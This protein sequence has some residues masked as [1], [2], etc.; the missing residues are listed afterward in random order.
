MAYD[1]NQAYAALSS[2]TDE[3]S[4][5][6]LLSEI[7]IQAPGTTTVAYSGLTAQSVPAF[8]LA[9]SLANA[10][11]NI[12]YIGNTDV[13]K[14][15]DLSQNR[16][17][18][19]KLFEIFDDDPRD[20][21][22][23]AGQFLGG[24]FDPY[25]NRIP[26]GIWDDISSRFMA[27]AS[28]DVRVIVFDA[29]A[30]RI[31]GSSELST[32]LNN[33]SVT[34]IEGID[35]ADLR[36]SMAKAGTEPLE[37]VFDR[38]KAASIT[39]LGLAGVTA[40]ALPD[41]S[42]DVRMRDF[43]S[44][45]ILD[46]EGYIKSNPDSIRELTAYLF[47]I[48]E[49]GQSKLQELL[50]S[51]KT[52]GEV[53][54]RGPGGKVMSRAGLIGLVLSGVI[55]GAQASTQAAKGDTR[56]AMRTI[57]DWAADQAGAAAGEVL[58][59]AVGGI[60]LGILAAGGLVATAPA[61][62][63]FVTM[64]AM[65]GGF[66]GG[67]AGKDFFALCQ[68]LDGNGRI[69]LMDKLATVLFGPN[70]AP[71]APLPADLNGGGRY[72]IDASLPRE[73]IVLQAAADIAW[74][75]ALRELNPFVITDVSYAAQNAD[76]SLDLYD[77]QT[78]EGQMTQ[79][80]LEDRGAM[81]AWK[82]RFDRA[83]LKGNR[84]LAAD[85]V[86]GD[87]DFVD[88]AKLGADGKPLQLSIDGRGFSVN[89]HR[90]VFGTRN[91]DAVDGSDKADRLYGMD[92]NDRLSGGA[93]DDYLEGGRGND[94]LIGG[95]G[96][97]VLAGGA[98]DDLLIG[99]AGQ[100]R[101]QGGRG[102]DNYILLAD[103]LAEPH[104][105]RIADVDGLGQL[106]IGRGKNATGLP[107][108]LQTLP[109]S[110]WVAQERQKPGDPSRWTN[111]SFT[112][113]ALATD[114]WL[115]ED[116]GPGLLPTRVLVTRNAADGSLELQFGRAGTQI[117]VEN[118]QSGRLGIEL[119]TGAHDL[120]SNAELRASDLKDWAYLQLAAGVDVYNQLGQDTQALA[121]RLSAPAGNAGT[122]ERLSLTQAQDLL[123]RYQIVT[124][125]GNDGAGFSATLFRRRDPV[126][127]R[128]VPIAGQNPDPYLLVFRGNDQEP[129]RVAG[130]AK[131]GGLAALREINR[132]GFAWAQLDA[133]ERFWSGLSR[134][135]VLTRAGEWVSVAGAEGATQGGLTVLGTG[136]GAHLAAAFTLLHEDR[137]ARGIGIDGP[138]IGGMQD[139]SADGRAITAAELRGKLQDFIRL[140]AYR[141]LPLGSNFAPAFVEAGVFD[142]YAAALEADR[143]SES[144]F[145]ALLNYLGSSYDT[146][147]LPVPADSGLT[148]GWENAWDGANIYASALYRFAADWLGR[149][150]V[151]AGQG[152]TADAST[153]G[154]GDAELRAA[155]NDL[156]LESKLDRVT[157][158][159]DVTT[160]RLTGPALAGTAGQKYLDLL[161]QTDR[162][163]PSALLGGQGYGGRTQSLWVEDAA[164]VD[165]PDNLD[166]LQRLSLEQGWGTNT[167]QRAIGTAG[168]LTRLA[169]SAALAELFQRIDSTVSL[170]A[171][172]AMARAASR[173]RVTASSPV[174]PGGGMPWAARVE[175]LD[176]DSLEQ[177]IAGLG[178]ILG[179]STP[180]PAATDIAGTLDPAKRAAWADAVS[181][182]HQRLGQL[183]VAG[184][185]LHL[186]DLTEMSGEQLAAMGAEDSMSGLATRLALQQGLP[187]ALVD[188][189]GRAYAGIDDPVAR[190]VPGSGQ[191]AASMEWLQDRAAWLAG[192]LT[193]RTHNL[194]DDQLHAVLDDKDTTSGWEARR[195]TYADAQ[196]GTRFSFLP[197]DLSEAERDARPE[198]LVTF[199]RDS[200][201]PGDQL[202][203]TVGA[204]WL[205]GQ[206]GDD[207]LLG[208]AGRD[209][210][211]GGAGD[212]LLQ[213]G[214]GADALRG[215]TGR[216]LL[217]GG[218]GGDVFV[219][220]RGDGV[221]TIIDSDGP[222]N[223]NTLS[224]GAGIGR[225]DLRI[226]R[227]GHT[228]TIHVQAAGADT[229]D[230]IRLMHFSRFTDDAGTPVTSVLAFDDGTQIELARLMNHAPQASTGTLATVT[231]TQ[232]SW[233]SA[234]LPDGLFTDADSDD[235][236]QWR[237]ER[238]NGTAAPAWLQFNPGTRTLFGRPPLDDTIELRVIATDRVGE[239]AH[240]DFTLNVAAAPDTDPVDG[241][242]PAPTLSREAVA[243][244]VQAGSSFTW[245]LASLGLSPLQAASSTVVTLSRADGSSL[246]SWIAYE[247]QTGLLRLTPEATEA[248]DMPLRVVAVNGDGAQSV[249]ALTLNVQ[250]RKAPSA[251]AAL[252][253]LQWEEGPSVA[254]QVPADAFLNLAAGVRYTLTPEDGSALPAG[255]QFDA[256]T[257]RL[258]GAPDASVDS[259]WRLRLTAR[260]V[261]GSTASQ[262]LLVQMAARNDAPQ[263]GALPAT[264]NAVQDQALQWTLPADAFSDEETPAAALAIR[265]T[266]AGGAPLPAWL[267]FDAGT[268]TLS[269]MPQ[270]GDVGTQTIEW[271]ATDPQGAATVATQQLTVSNV[272]D[273]PVLAVPLA[274]VAATQGQALAVDLPRAAFV[275]ADG[276]TLTVELTRADGSA[277]P[278][279]LRLEPAGAGGSL[280]RLSGTPGAGDIGPV[281]VRLTVRDA[282][283]AQASDRF[284]VQV[285]D[286]NDAPQVVQPLAPVTVSAYAPLDVTL[287]ALAFS[288]PD[289]GERLSWQ[290]TQA[291]GS[292][293]PGWLQFDAGTRRLTGRAV[294]ADVGDHALRVRVTD[295]WGATAD[296]L[297]NLQVQAGTVSNQAPTPGAALAPWRA[298]A[299]QTFSTVLPLGLFSDADVF[300]S[301]TFS[302]TQDDGS[303]LP[304]WLQFDPATQ[305][306]IGTVPVDQA[307]GI[308][309]RLTATDRDGA[310][311]HQT[312]SLVIES[313]D[314]QKTGGSGDDT[315]LGSEGND[316]LNGGAGHDSLTG[317]AG[318]DRLDGQDGNDSLNGES[319]DDLLFG[320]NGA[321]RL[322]GGTGADRLEGGSADDMLWG[323]DG[324]DVLDGGAGRDLLIGGSGSDTVAFR[325]GDGIDELRNGSDAADP[326]AEAQATQDIVRLEGIR[327]DETLVRRRFDDLLL[328]FGGGDQLTLT[329]FFLGGAARNAVAVDALRFDDGTVWNVDDLV[330]RSMAGTPGD[331]LLWGLSDTADQLAGAAG[332]DNL[333]GL[334]GDDQLLGE[335]GSDTLDGGD[336]ADRLDGGAG[337]DLL[338]GGAGNDRLVGGAGDDGLAFRSAD[339]N[340][341]G[342]LYGGE[343]DDELA[344]GT[345]DD[346]LA[347]GAGSDTYRFE[348]GDGHDRILSH[349]LWNG[350]SDKQS[351]GEIDRLVFGEGIRPTD[352]SMARE[353]STLVLRLTGSQ[354]RVDLLAYFAGETTSNG[355][356]LDEIRFADGTVWTGEDV[357]AALLRTSSN[358]DQVIGYGDSDDAL[359]GGDGDDTLWGRAGA[360]VLRGGNGRDELQ[361]ETGS[362][363]LEGGAGNDQLDGGADDDQLSGDDGSDLLWGR[364]G[365]DRLLG[366]AGDDTGELY[367]P[368]QIGDTEWKLP[369][370]GLYGGAGDDW[371]EGGTGADTLVGGE[372]SDTYAFWR[373]DGQ[374]R[375]VNYDTTTGLPHAQEA[376]DVDTLR[377][378]PGITPDD[379]QLA[380]D[381]D[382]LVITRSGSDDRIRIERSFV[383][384]S[385]DHGY[386]L[387]AWVFD[388]GRRWTSQDILQ[389]LYGASAQ[390]PQVVGTPAALQATQDETQVFDLPA[391]WFSDAP[392][393]RL[394]YRLGL[395]G[396]LPLPDWLR[397]EPDASGAG[398]GRLVATPG[399]AQVG[400]VRLSLAA[401]DPLG[402]RTE[403]PLILNVQNRND[404]PVAG[405][406]P[407]VL[408]A[409]EDRPFDVT[410][411]A[412]L[413][414]DPDGASDPLS[415]SVRSSDGSTLPDWLSFDP[416][417]R[418]LSGTP[419]NAAVGTTGLRLRATDGGGLWADMPLSVE[420]ANVNDAPHAGPGATSFAVTAY[421]VFTIGL[422]PDLVVDDDAGDTLSLDLRLADGSA[423]PGWLSFD[424]DTATLHGRAVGSD[425]GLHALRL[426]ATDGAG[427]QVD[428]GLQLQIGAGTARNAA[429]VVDAWAPITSLAGA[430]LAW[431]LPPGSFRDADPWDPLT[432]DIRGPGDTALP[433]GLAFDPISG[434]LTGSLG[435]PGDWSFT[436]RA[437]D[438]DGA[439]ALQ[440]LDV[441]VL[442]PALRADGGEASERMDGA[443][444]DDHLRGMGGSDALYGSTGHDTLEGGDGDDALFGGADDDTLFGAAGDDGLEGE[445]GDDRLFGQDGSDRLTG[446]AGDDTLD[447]GTGD[448][449]LTGGSG[450]DNYLWGA[451]D[452]HDRIDNRPVDSG[453][454]GVDQ[455]LFKPGIRPQDLI[456]ERL[457]DVDVGIRLRDGSGS[458]LLERFFEGNRAD[459]ATAIERLRFADGTTWTPDDVLQRASTAVAIDA[460]LRGVDDR[461]NRLAGSTGQDDLRGGARAD[462]LLG[463]A[464]RDRLFGGAGDDRLLGGDGDDGGTVNVGG[465]P[466]QLGL[467]GE[468]GDDEL[469]GGAGN[470]ELSGGRGSDRFHFG[471]GYG[472][473]RIASGLASWLTPDDRDID[474]L[475][476][477]PGIGLSDLRMERQG[478]DL[479]IDI[480]GT[481][482][483]VT[484]AGQFSGDRLAD[485]GGIDA[486]EWADGSRTALRELAD[487]FDRGD[488]RSQTLR[489]F[490]DHDDHL[491]GLAGYDR[492]MGLG[493][494]DWLEGGDDQDTLWGDD[495]NDRLWGGAG[496]D[497]GWPDGSLG[498]LYG[499]AGDDELRGGSGTDYLRGGAGSD[500]YRFERGDGIDRI[501]NWDQH[502]YVVE[503]LPGDRD[504]LIFGEGI[505]P[506]D[507]RVRK[508]GDHLILTRSGTGDQVQVLDQLRVDRVAI[509]S[510]L[511]EIRFA[512]GTVWRE[513]D[514]IARVQQLDGADDVYIG[515]EDLADSVSGGA[516]SDRLY[517]QAGNDVLDGGTGIDRLE[518]GAGDDRL[519]GGE[520]DDGGNF[521]SDMLGGIVAVGGLF[522]GDGD[523]WLDGGAGRDALSG[524]AG[525]DSFNFGLGSGSDVVL[526]FQ[527]GADAA[528]ADHVQLGSGIEAA[529]LTLTR[530]VSDLVLRTPLGDTLSLLGYFTREIASDAVVIRF[531]DGSSWNAG[532]LQQRV[533]TPTEGADVLIL[534][535]EQN[536]AIQAGGGD[537]RVE[538][539]GGDDRVLGGSGNDLLITG[540]GRD[541][542]DGDDGDDVLMLGDG[543]DTGR[544]GAGADRLMGDAGND[545]LW[546]GD[547]DDA[548]VTNAGLT[549]LRGLFGGA[550]DDLLDGGAGRDLL[551]GDAGNDLLLGGAGDDAGD[552]WYQMADATDGTGGSAGAGLYGGAGDD[553]LVGGAG[554]DAM[555]GG[556]GSDNYR[557]GRGEGQDRILDWH[558]VDPL[559]R[560]A[561][562]QAETDSLIFE[563][564][565][566]PEDVRAERTGVDLLLH[567]DGGASSVRVE[568]YFQGDRTDHDYRLDAIQFADGTVWHAADVIRLVGVGT[569]TRDY[570]TAVA[571]STVLAGMDGDDILMAGLY[572][573][574]T[575][576]LTL[577]GGNGHDQLLG[578]MGDETLL[579]GAGNDRLEANAG[580]D[581]LIG[582]PGSDRIDT[583]PG[584][585]HVVFGRGDGSDFVLA[586]GTRTADVVSVHL[587]DGLTPED[588][589]VRV[590][591]N[592][593]QL[594]IRQT[595]DQI[596][597]NM[598][599]QGR[600]TDEIDQILFADGTRWGA[601]D[602]Y[603][604]LG[605]GTA[606]PETMLGLATD[607]H[608]QG[609][610]GQDQ[611]FGSAGQDRLDGDAGNDRL[612]G[613]AG[614]DTLDGGSGDDLL[615]GG[616]G[617]DSYRFGLGGGQ[618]TV[619]EDEG[620]TSPDVIDRLE[621]VGLRPD[622][623]SVSRESER[624]AVITLHASGERV[625][626]WNA[627]NPS[628]SY[629]RIE[630]V[631]FADGTVWTPADLLSATQQG[632][633]GDDVL[634]GTTGNDTLH[635]YAGADT[636]LGLSG[637]DRLW[638][639]EGNDVLD[640]GAGSDALDGGSGNDRA[641]FGAPRSTWTV[642]RV[643]DNHYRLSNGSDVDELL[644]I[645]TLG[646]SDQSLALTTGGVQLDGSVPKTGRPVQWIDGLANNPVSIDGVQWQALTA[647][648]WTDISGATQSDYTPGDAQIGQAL[649]VQ[650][651]FSDPV[652]T[653]QLA[654][655][656][657]SAP[658]E[659]GNHRPVGLPVIAGTA[660]EDATLWADMSGVSDADGLGGF[661]WQWLRD[662][663]AVAGATG[664]SFVPVD[665]DVGGR[666]GLQVAWT[667]GGGTREN[668]V[669]PDTAPVAN[670]NDLPMGQP[671]ILG[672]AAEREKLTA[673]LSGISDADGLG[674]VQLQWT[675]DG[676]A[677]AGATGTS[678]QLGRDDVGHLI[679]LEL[680]YVDGHGSAEVLQAVPTAP[681]IQVN[682]PP[683][684]SLNLAGT[685]AA[686]QTLTA[687]STLADA[688]GL[689]T[690]RWHW[691][692]E[693]A[694][695]W[696]D[697]HD[698]LTSAS[699]TLTA[700]Q[701]GLRVRA[702]ADYLDGGGTWESAASAPSAIVPML[703]FVT[704]T[705][706]AGKDSLSGRKDPDRLVGLA[707]NDTLNGNAGMDLM[708]GGK[709]NDSYVVDHV[710]D[711]IVEAAAE[712][713]D[714]VQSSVS[715]TLP[716]NVDN[717]TL[718]GSAAIN[719][720]GN[721]LDN[722][723]TGN[724]AA[725]VLAGG[726]GNDTLN[727]GAGADTL[728]GGA[729]NDTLIGG[730]GADLYRFGSGGGKDRIQ[731]NDK[732]SG[733][734]DRV[735]FDAGI[736]PADTRFTRNGN[737]LQ[738]GLPGGSDVL[739]IEDWYL[740][741]RYHVEQ[742]A[743]SD[744]TVLTARQAAGL[745]QAIASFDAMATMVADRTGP[746]LPLTTEPL[747]A[748]PMP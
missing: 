466:Q 501:A 226:E 293:L 62:A 24:S 349:D 165:L 210:L 200:A 266:G 728:D 364:D 487:A 286:V 301:L 469:D 587:G 602:L 649:R 32:L 331:D 476:L 30:K 605:L 585:D 417:T 436:L 745:V 123:S 28:G 94:Q 177:L 588:L 329:G 674:D 312:A 710:G 368:Y 560:V 545:G 393:D 706:T 347:G 209:H 400:E 93:G 224:F 457:G 454:D 442:A 334:A 499:G 391:G 616:T 240:I 680:R 214:E 601:A 314:S 744:G 569:A 86:A 620:E 480:I 96:D 35:V 130:V 50:D 660:T 141:D 627:F 320:G 632:S 447:G 233:F 638:G 258:S 603:A 470:D 278:A 509:G 459:S 184:S 373:G 176:T 247:P 29:D 375:I 705:G 485:G 317:R 598:L 345:G 204:D 407:A 512:D 192:S 443:S 428:I 405:T 343:G 140:M 556:L 663:Q 723:L 357:R 437:M 714:S 582:G 658:V 581:W 720:T 102:T 310:Q 704:K 108:E 492:L 351:P 133:M 38:V 242:W 292:A 504:V 374:D 388:D 419:G 265:V 309:L 55:T 546:A 653:H 148:Q 430:P 164:G 249:A 599:A 162:L 188:D 589:T 191:G 667:D 82:Q 477:G 543:D 451:G 612:Y 232:R 175:S 271:H 472:Q 42:F 482:D 355:L 290:L 531:A 573:T 85:E 733:V 231:A 304:A 281:E 288:D 218:A 441:R 287:D 595:N 625:T 5:R 354:D 193:L 406:P 645:E 510:A 236:L 182:L 692:V 572:G 712:G 238:A 593:M 237:V 16:Q 7:S 524:G 205:Y 518:G 558:F 495:G 253:P 1:L 127:A 14:F 686:G 53:F 166:A 445:T 116:S 448:D 348:R 2:V 644:G 307:S 97:D 196:D 40:S 333:S 530:T 382:A 650:V 673:E 25:G 420:V 297:L 458:L 305:Q 486:L 699:F 47:R 279:W 73:Q 372:G 9:E 574:S 488:E 484:L 137:V 719:A 583:G 562:P 626:L 173:N 432:I 273:A 219:F 596:T 703:A 81:L 636:L 535:G 384:G 379:L 269:G 330:R 657:S 647:S 326:L 323:G 211:E 566:A 44:K 682:A 387:D 111:G 167:S 452:G 537:D 41:G 421:D 404:A 402:L 316:A 502:R 549:V 385:M 395:E 58:G 145:G 147:G 336:G 683:T 328:Q 174:M 460:T 171:F 360:D 624:D 621:L 259:S 584:S 252:E 455:L 380:R 478:T 245:T 628:A 688:D 51:L 411:D 740:G 736:T 401:V 446:G 161:A 186:I 4:L 725:N 697:I 639:D 600:I 54:M 270:A 298:L 49:A 244:D 662:G 475:A 481:S 45:V 151:G 633:P 711:G 132:Q 497:G 267:R 15:M 128:G 540:A 64:A 655:S 185:R 34:S 422:P 390:A 202:A 313:L 641:S 95:A 555:S 403:L 248:G 318:H 623:V 113:T 370:G 261:N 72:T 423:L 500:V 31:F 597:L 696:S 350:R 614:N 142:A 315:L 3:L 606:A 23:R 275:D 61:A 79:A 715:L 640:G 207:A 732:T 139:G 295:S 308:A 12:R 272:N 100:N 679:G 239:S 496:D 208:R 506:D 552:G 277:L 532:F 282:A 10:D 48:E 327:P 648:G 33:P 408:L 158:E 105:H 294:Q 698:N 303:P 143:P 180:T 559:T 743:Y 542:A 551:M 8:K 461:D 613:E 285:H 264:L 425:V 274:D 52:R 734:V 643:A 642:T 610:D 617:A 415:W 65:A 369:A 203:G 634:N 747:W 70:A 637:D 103:Q 189:S 26:N 418:R 490:E 473:D 115:L 429:P 717:L 678:W 397:F 547:G 444:G 88:L 150:T 121:A 356:R 338:D 63:V 376:G 652:A 206:A 462:E 120:P 179:V 700:A 101:L 668:L 738:V 74:R 319:G 37:A 289:A 439:S 656:P 493:G 229:G 221:D 433:A 302:V 651:W 220:E 91:A 483:R 60:A 284:V 666:I 427:A 729:G 268:R 689:G 77:E 424:A 685:L 592:G 13:S 463:A 46:T 129:Q 529:S 106:S 515:F 708:I 536:R 280:G 256:T 155:W 112:L 104:L 575:A 254:W 71:G 227:D 659:V 471:R 567:I 456:V 676:A 665:D 366:G 367:T 190:R 135:R 742:F 365:N 27:A 159:P 690:L 138:G 78:G 43:G 234:A 713:V 122:G 426:R 68:D 358:A 69:E 257:G 691:Q 684:G 553:Q 126:D 724:S 618:D 412:T 727:A 693:S 563:A 276:E 491:V 695:S 195:W 321:D 378:G 654:V 741:A 178:R 474:V 737:A 646:F 577:D 726:D 677:I 694:G 169:D 664:S 198:S 262:A 521:S 522:G 299:G 538:T 110:G 19:N 134:G 557:I 525:A 449:R 199:G 687:T 489:G 117:V 586:T 576:A 251:G 498:G 332:D 534:T 631:V 453:V 168:T 513:A 80:Y 57:G 197:Q 630:Q 157:G 296:N 568:R 527:A 335:A 250:P 414:R 389:R 17:L 514:W 604:R 580:N 669:A 608:L 160:W 36:A 263:T 75:Y 201:G 539:G 109:L 90:V 550:G 114:R 363:T 371:L 342:G 212:D 718:T 675:R 517:G 228:L 434:L 507:M 579:G 410:L 672:V 416:Q 399:N 622:D 216:D 409:Q 722:T 590:D 615:Q 479:L 6:K 255:L 516:G 187:F 306:L 468:D 503:A 213:G 241:V 383:D 681:V 670:V 322:S 291:D 413:F 541:E 450:A 528:Q 99:G 181:R 709:G 107:Q 341:G 520:G 153:G 508:D 730:S 591:I 361:G 702:V 76:G 149:D 467:F 561:K 494:D 435:L 352:V 146:N 661:E 84:Q 438:R 246:P 300:N 283:G 56:G 156:Q 523:D 92:G 431:Q 635:G 701:A 215:G 671:L 464:G 564:G 607:D 344:G 136:V 721:R 629:A 386:G 519:S 746:P 59:G 124:Q 194:R 526:D 565:I 346:Y 594:A 324:D 611:L 11:P 362:D 735:A 66:F 154:V 163:A 440:A 152:Q 21:K 89:D 739:T 260:D 22:T 311:A 144:H 183:E 217:A 398:I 83:G 533:T 554:N 609:G 571:G 340:N 731:E 225:D 619:L 381:G 118:W 172:A 87:W 222:R 707:G 98:G 119:P 339:A 505:R 748:V 67:D 465:W 396:G 243:V 20:P 578:E 377:F 394:H 392:E 511:A 359:D 548:P 223:T 544:G 337:V 230:A 570:L 131:D 716:V 39:H 125:Y 353:G 18:L 325:R 170:D 235:R